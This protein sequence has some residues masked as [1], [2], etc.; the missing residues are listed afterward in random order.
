MNKLITCLAI[1]IIIILLL[2]LIFNRFNESFEVDQHKLNSF[3]SKIKAIQGYGG[4][5]INI[6]H[7]DTNNFK[8]LIND[9]DGH[10]LGL[11]EDG[12]LNIVDKNSE[13][14]TWT[15]L[16]IHNISS[17]L[18]NI[19]KPSDESNTIEEASNAMDD[20][21]DDEDQYQYQTT[22][23]PAVTTLAPAVTTLAPTVTTLAPAVT[24]LAPA[25]TT[26]APAVTTLAPTVTTL[27]PTAAPIAGGSCVGRCGFYD[28]S[29]N[30]QCDTQCSD[31]DKD[32]CCPDYNEQCP[33]ATTAATTAAPTTNGA[34]NYLIEIC[35]SND[36]PTEWTQLSESAET[37]GITTDGELKNWKISIDKNKF[38]EAKCKEPPSEIPKGWII[39]KDDCSTECQNDD[40][41]ENF[42]MEL[43]FYC[44]DQ[45]NKDQESTSIRAR[46][47]SK[48]NPWSNAPNL[49]ANNISGTEN[50]WKF[51][52][53]KSVLND[54]DKWVDED[55]SKG[56]S[57]EKLLKKLQ[58]KCDDQMETEMNVKEG[59][60][61]GGG[62]DDENVD[63]L[64]N[65]PH[66]FIMKREGKVYMLQYL[67]GNVISTKLDFNHAV[68]LLSLIRQISN[69]PMVK[70]LIVRNFGELWSVN[71]QPTK[72]KE[73]RLF[74]TK[75]T[76]FGNIPYSDY[77]H[78]PNKIKINLNI[79]DKNLA[80]LFNVQNNTPT[81]PP[82]KCDTYL[83][84]SVVSSLCPGCTP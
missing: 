54:T 64:I 53:E 67:S 38:C 1:I 7:L 24:T 77:D 33:T 6:K 68:I 43:K 36:I 73:L 56:P 61:S 18:T 58:E 8:V 82:K 84:R 3:Y 42:P 76:H 22:A 49:F 59:F 12:V 55:G 11:N 19:L 20:D 27:A 4:V 14:S 39:G 13:Y 46:C 52:I 44:D 17:E 9:T 72:T 37:Y 50:K 10:V 30:C 70:S 35:D 47:F 32:D 78:D 48:N 16:S 71:T 81:T 75:N 26:L 41:W 57:A 83:P 34:D 21:D 51:S 62:G 5:K 63:D 28:G 69:D 74:N 79:K 40:D 66:I 15:L 2:G 65:I 45:F 31:M 60:Q 23:A 80:G 29:K 25:V